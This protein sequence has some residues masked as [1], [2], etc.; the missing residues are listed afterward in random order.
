MATSTAKTPKEYI[1]S[2]PEDRRDTVKKLRALIR[3][4]LPKGYVEQMRWGFICYEVPL[5]VCPET[6][7]GEPLMYAAIAAQKRHYG[8]YMCGMYVLPRVFKNLTEEWKKRGTRLD[9]GKSCIRIQSWEKCEVD[10]IAD[11]IAS[12]PMAEFVAATN[13]ATSTRKKNS[14]KKKTSKKKTAK[15]KT[16]RKKITKKKTAKKKVARK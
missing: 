9:I 14:A 11:T 6:Y 12:V 13:A 1:E 7:N 3:K 16:T 8:I 15:K 4:N 10:L 5:S 2:L